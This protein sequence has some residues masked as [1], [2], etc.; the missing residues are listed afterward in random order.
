MCVCVC[1]CVRVCAHLKDDDECQSGSEHS[2]VLQ[3]IGSCVVG[4]RL[5]GILTKLTEP[6]NTD[7]STSPQYTGNE[8]VV[9]VLQHLQ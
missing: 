7:N 6:A 1:A 3:R 8:Q 9:C 5:H 2:P 4:V